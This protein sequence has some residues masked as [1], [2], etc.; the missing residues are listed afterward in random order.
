VGPDPI[1]EPAPADS[2]PPAAQEVA[3]IAARESARFPRLSRGRLNR[4]DLREIS[5]LLGMGGNP[6]VHR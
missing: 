1:A 2:Q 5:S 3:E 4:T 6:E